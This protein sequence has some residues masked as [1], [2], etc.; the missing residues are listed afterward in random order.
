MYTPLGQVS[1]SA[2][3]SDIG[4][5]L[6]LLCYDKHQL[7]EG[8]VVE[9]I[10]DQILDSCNHP[11]SSTPYVITI[12]KS[13]GCRS[14]FA[15]LWARRK[16][17]YR[18][19]DVVK[20]FSRNYETRIVGLDVSSSEFVTSRHCYKNNEKTVFNIELEECLRELMGNR[21]RDYQV[22]Q[23]VRDSKRQLQTIWGGLFNSDSKSLLY[24]ALLPRILKNFYF[25]RFFDFQWDVDRIAFI[26]NQQGNT[27]AIEVKHK[28]PIPQC[29]SFGLNTGEVQLIK[30]LIRSGV[31][32]CHVIFVK[33]F[34]DS[35]SPSINLLSNMKAR[36][37]TKII[38]VNVSEDLIN[39]LINSRSEESPERTTL[40]GSGK[41]SYKKI[42]CNCFKSIGFLN[43]RLELL[44]AN[45]GALANN[46]ELENQAFSE[47]E[48]LR[49]V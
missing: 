22:D 24:S 40:S 8:L 42:A 4:L 39:N 35:K 15:F 31:V 12:T 30:Q 18:F 2:L 37:R 21:D 13:I 41:L 38:G 47:L 27:A 23:E 32:F 14:K 25:H 3:E 28:F 17:D 19:L 1:L 5:Q 26:E 45:F 43:D 16:D 20:I 29:G 11:I 46:A 6:K 7:L 44:G 36:E 33:P 10:F 34:W 48:S 9:N 49:I